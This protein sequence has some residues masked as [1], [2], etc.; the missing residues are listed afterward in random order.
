VTRKYIMKNEVVVKND[1]W[2]HGEV[3]LL[4]GTLRKTVK[5]FQCRMLVEHRPLFAVRSGR[6]STNQ[7]NS[8]VASST[9]ASLKR[10]PIA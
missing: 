2:G 4:L 5:I 6:Y 8:M 9:I 7:Y 3:P 1:F 10:I